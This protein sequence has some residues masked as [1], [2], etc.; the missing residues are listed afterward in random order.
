MDSDDE[1]DRAAYQYH[2]Q[3]FD[4]E[5]SE[6]GVASWSDEEDMTDHS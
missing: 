1:Y 6:V 2:T 4:D 5:H 3:T